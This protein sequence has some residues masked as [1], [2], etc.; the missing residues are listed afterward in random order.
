[1]AINI[2]SDKSMCGNSLG[3]QWWKA[4]T[5]DNKTKP[6]RQA[7]S[8]DNWWNLSVS[9]SNLSSLISH[10]KTRINRTWHMLGCPHWS[11]CY[12]DYNINLWTV[13]LHDPANDSRPV[14]SKAE[15]W[16]HVL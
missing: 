12:T 5:S 4:W 2:K 11:A 7:L 14:P 6:W 8:S 16:E 9:K 3:R 1:M 10:L 15:Q 13:Q